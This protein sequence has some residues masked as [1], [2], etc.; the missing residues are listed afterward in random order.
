MPDDFSTDTNTS[1][2]VTVDGTASGDIESSGDRDWFAVD[3]VA[4]R[5]YTIELR[6]GPTADGTLSDP[7][8]RGIHDA[9]GN[10]IARTTNATGVT[11]TTA[12]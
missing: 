11:A 7:Y 8:L 9:D 2:S 4:G 10:L 1:G 12:R 5:T 3:L 6:G